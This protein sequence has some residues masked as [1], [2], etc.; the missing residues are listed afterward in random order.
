MDLS[1]QILERIPAFIFNE[2]VKINQQTASLKD[3]FPPT[4]R[5]SY[6]YSVDSNRKCADTVFFLHS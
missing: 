4:N 3:S 5:N 6:S 1:A 2:D